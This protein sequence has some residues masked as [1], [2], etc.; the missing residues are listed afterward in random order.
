M[1][2]SV[3]NDFIR[4]EEGGF[5]EWKVEFESVLSRQAEIQNRLEAASRQLEGCISLLMGV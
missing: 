3:L 5:D 2:Q 1:L 4:I